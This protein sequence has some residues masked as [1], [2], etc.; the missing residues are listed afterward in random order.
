MEAGGRRFNFAILSEKLIVSICRIMVTDYSVHFTMSKPA[1]TKPAQTKS[2]QTKH[3][4]MKSKPTQTQAS[5][6]SAKVEGKKESLPRYVSVELSGETSLRLHQPIIDLGKS[7]G[8]DLGLYEIKR[9]LADHGHLTMVFSTDLDLDLYRTV[10]KEYEPHRDQSVE[11][12]VT[13]VAIDSTCIALSAQ[14]RQLKSYPDGRHSHITMMLHNQA[15]VY[16]NT[17]L[18]RIFSD[19]KG[20]S[21]K[22]E[23]G[24]TYTVGSE[25]TGDVAHYHHLKEPLT[26]S[27]LL[28]FIGYLKIK[29]PVVP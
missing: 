17:L 23:E 11:I 24:Q 9:G 26:V 25:E 29:P 2:V 21:I 6:S 7:L 13:G 15:P 1:Q 18:T 4:Q 3:G 28:K 8:I 10:I 16:S 14:P 27:G 5:E 20:K 22:L 12:Q 19:L